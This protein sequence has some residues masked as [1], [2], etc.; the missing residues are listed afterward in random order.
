MKQRP[1]GHPL[2]VKR[3]TTLHYLLEIATIIAHREKYYDCPTII[4]HVFAHSLDAKCADAVGRFEMNME[5]LGPVAK[6]AM[7]TIFITSS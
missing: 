5:K 4:R 3:S 1:R 2:E 6:L 7:E